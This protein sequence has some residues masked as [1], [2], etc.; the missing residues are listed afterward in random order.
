MLQL[1]GLHIIDC[2]ANA[3]VTKQ[4]VSNTS[5]LTVAMTGAERNPYDGNN[6]SFLPAGHTDLCRNRPVDTTNSAAL[7]STYIT[8]T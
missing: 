3:G 8:F 7:I 1:Q 6:L 5:T 2:E 4:W